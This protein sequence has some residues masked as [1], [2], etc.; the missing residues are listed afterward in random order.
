MSKIKSLLTIVCVSDR[1][2]LAGDTIPLDL[3]ERISLAAKSERA[4]ELLVEKA[5]R[6]RY[7][8]EIDD[9]QFLATMSFLIAAQFRR[10]WMEGLREVDYKDGMTPDM[11]NELA[12]YEI[13]EEGHSRR[14]L[15]DIVS[16]IALGLGWEVFAYRISLWSHR[17]TEIRNRAAVAGGKKRGVRL[18]WDL[19][20]TEKHCGTCSQYS[21]QIKSAQEWDSI[22]LTLQHAPQSRE[23][24]CKGYNCDCELNRV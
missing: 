23:L 7:N 14:L 19:G 11:E 3:V 5:V 20:R 22:W 2:L 1:M 8:Q 13:E 9:G 17:Y 10:A 21:G 6:D 18:R 12:G 16:A 4:Y 24:D 15:L